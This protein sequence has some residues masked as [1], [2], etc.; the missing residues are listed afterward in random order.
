MSF[1]W[2][3]VQAVVIA[4]VAIIFFYI[5]QKIKEKPVG[6]EKSEGDDFLYREKF[7]LLNEK[8]QVLFNRL[9]EALPNLLVLTQ[10]SMSQILFTGGQRN[11]VARK[12]VDFLICWKD[13]SIVAAIEFNGATHKDP[14]RIKSDE[15]KQKVLKSAGIPLITYLSEQFPEI[16]QIRKDIAPL[17]IEREKLKAQRIRNHSPKS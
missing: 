13:T 14:K 11:E 2:L 17:L 16:P 10:V 6:E 12:S 3:V 9:T 8:E 5:K 1:K 7:N 4:L 15:V